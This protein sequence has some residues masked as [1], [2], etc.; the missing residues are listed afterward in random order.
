M[1]RNRCLTAFIIIFLVSF[2]VSASLSERDLL[3]PVN[4][5]TVYVSKILDGTVAVIDAS[6]DELITLLRTGSNPAEVAVVDALDRV[7]VADLTDGTVTVIDTTDHSIE[8]TIAVG[9]PV[10]AVGVDQSLQRVYALDFSNGTPGTNL[11]EIDANTNIETAD[12]TIGSRLQNI[13]MDPDESRAYATDFVDGVIVI[14]TSSLTVVTYLPVSNLPHGVAVHPDLNRLYVTQL[15]S[16]TVTVIDTTTHGVVGDNA[17]GRKFDSVHAGEISVSRTR[18]AA[19]SKPMLSKK[20]ASSWS[21]HAT[22]VRTRSMRSALR[23]SRSCSKIARATPRRSKA[24]S[25]STVSSTASGSGRPNSPYWTAANIAPTN[26][27][28]LSATN[29]TWRSLSSSASLSL[30][31]YQRCRL[32]PVIFSSMATSRERSSDLRLRMTTPGSSV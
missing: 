3:Q 14:D 21:F 4:T 8:E 15:D 17:V 11:H 16:D 12:V 27:P 23:L 2:L 29:E 28:S 31:S 5:S 25:T 10:A 13:A 32:R 26:R 30:P 9:H 19:G 20:A 24:G 22:S 1:N 6:T 7:Y 18:R